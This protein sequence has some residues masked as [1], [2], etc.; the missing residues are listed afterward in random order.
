[1]KNI[2]APLAVLIIIALVVIA[3]LIGF[4]YLNRPS[5][6]PVGGVA[7]S[8]RPITPGGQPEQA[9]QEGGRPITPTY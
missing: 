2:P 5:P 1:M 4:W 6:A 3:V 9:G 8:P 7:T